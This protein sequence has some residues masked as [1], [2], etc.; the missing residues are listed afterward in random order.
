VIISLEEQTIIVTGGAKRLGRAIAIECAQAGANVIITYH[1]SQTEAEATIEE[2]QALAP[3]QE[4]AAFQLDVSNDEAVKMF[5]TSV[6]EKFTNVRGL[7][8]CA[9]IFERTPFESLEEKDFDSH[10]GANLKGPFLL[11]T[12]FAK[13]FLKIAPETDNSN[14]SI[15]NFADIYASRPL[16][17]YIPYCISKAGVLMLTQSMAKALAPRIRVNCIA[18]GTIYLPN[19]DDKSYGND[20]LLLKRIPYNRMGTAAEITQT[21]LFLLNGPQFIVGAVLPVDGGQML[22]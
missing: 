1:S 3:E 15:V 17:N 10:I 19:E 14:A 7:V 9:A 18:P 6:F 20:E 2:L 8:N 11:S 12:H 13:A 5:I 4:F 21:V 22:R 16:A